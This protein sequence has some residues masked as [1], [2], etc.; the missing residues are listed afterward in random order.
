MNKTNKTSDAMLELCYKFTRASKTLT[1]LNLGR[2]R[3]NLRGVL[4]G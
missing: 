3:C 4:L 2:K 1:P